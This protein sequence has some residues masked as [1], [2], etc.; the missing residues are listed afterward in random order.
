MALDILP[1]LVRPPNTSQPLVHALKASPDAR[2]HCRPARK[3]LNL[4]ACGNIC[5]QLSITVMQSALHLMPVL[6]FI[7]AFLYYAAQPP[8]ATPFAAPETSTQASQ[9]QAPAETAPVQQPANAGGFLSVHQLHWTMLNTI[10]KV[11]Y[12]KAHVIY[13][14][15]CHG[16]C[17]LF[18]RSVPSS[19][20][21]LWVNPS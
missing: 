14:E 16:K 12:A 3:A 18:L 11:I 19:H 17:R 8:S 21:F 4:T 13:N 5:S 10:R 2:L 1:V 9:S 15:H 7:Q 6:S 20:G